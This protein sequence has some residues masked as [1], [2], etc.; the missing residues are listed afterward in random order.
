MASR[1][2]PSARALA[3]THDTGELYRLRDRAREIGDAD[4]LQLLEQSI[5]DQARA[6]LDE[7]LE[8]AAESE[9]AEAAP[10]GGQRE[11]LLERDIAPDGE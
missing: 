7:G 5:L 10:S 8:K 11:V 4:A 2:L 1:R 9:A 3:K 6:E